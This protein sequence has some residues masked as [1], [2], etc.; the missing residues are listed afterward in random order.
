MVR[1]QVLLRDTG[2][3]GSVIVNVEN[4]CSSSSTAFYLACSAVAAG[5]AEIALAIGSEQL[6]VPDKTRAY[7]ALAAASDTERRPDMRAVVRQLAL[8][9]AGD[10]PL[11]SSSPLMEHYA[12]KGQAYL[13]RSGATVEDLALLVVKSRRF[14]QLNLKAHFTRGVTLEEVLASRSWRRLCTC[15]CAL[16]SATA[17]PQSL[18]TASSA[19]T[20]TQR[21]SRRAR[22]RRSPPAWVGRRTAT[23]WWSP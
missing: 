15:T 20:G 4:A 22:C 11:P 9:E 16:P 10:E 14:G 6:V 18:R 13:D 5:Q 2:L 17:R 3:L 23:C 21:R 8:G 19:G 1:G 12:A 7:A